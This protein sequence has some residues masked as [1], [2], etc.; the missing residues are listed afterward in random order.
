MKVSSEVMTRFADWIENMDFWKRVTIETGI[1]EYLK[2]MNNIEIPEDAEDK[3]L[4]QEYNYSGVVLEDVIGRDVRARN[5][6][7]F[8]DIKSCCFPIHWISARIGALVSPAMSVITLL[9]YCAIF[10]LKPLMNTMQIRVNAML[11]VL[12]MSIFLGIGTLVVSITNGG[13]VLITSTSLVTVICMVFVENRLRTRGK[14]E[15]GHAI[16]GW[17]IG[18]IFEIFLLAINAMVTYFSGNSIFVLVTYVHSACTPSVITNVRDQWYFAISPCDVMSRVGTAIFAFSSLATT[19]STLKSPLDRVYGGFLTGQVLIEVIRS[20]AMWVDYKYKMDH[21]CDCKV[22][23]I[24]LTGL[25]PV[26]PDSIGNQVGCSGNG[27]AMV[28]VPWFFATTFFSPVFINNIFLGLL[29]EMCCPRCFTLRWGVRHPGS[30][31][32]KNSARC[33]KYILGAK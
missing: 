1:L 29:A 10:I 8:R 31:S 24:N 32:V 15:N 5:T 18:D 28:E 12:V 17:R 4:Q 2:G 13:D 22:R 27:L 23:F 30:S 11:I 33:E 3:V 7:D 6:C 14:V 21:G 26:L 25:Q 9:I 19:L 16:V 20:I